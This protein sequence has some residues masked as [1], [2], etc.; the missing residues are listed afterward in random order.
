MDLHSDFISNC[1]NVS[2]RGFLTGVLESSL[3]EVM[4][5][6]ERRLRVIDVYQLPSVKGVRIVQALDFSALYP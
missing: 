4:S 6:D 5:I 1:F 3:I 2:Q